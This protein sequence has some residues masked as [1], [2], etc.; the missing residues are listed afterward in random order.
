M[1]LFERFRPA[2]QYRQRADDL[3]IAGDKRRC[4]VGEAG[5]GAGD[6]NALGRKA[7]ILAGIRNQQRHATLQHPLASCRC[8]WLVGRLESEARLEPEPVVVHPAHV[9]I[10]GVAQYRRKLRQLIQRGVGVAIEQAQFRAH[11][12][13]LV[14]SA[15]RTEHCA[16]KYT[17]PIVSIGEIDELD[18]STNRS[19]EDKQLTTQ[20]PPVLGHRIS[21]DITLGAF[22]SYLLPGEYRHT[23]SQRVAGRRRNCSISLFGPRLTRRMRSQMPGNYEIVDQCFR[24]SFNW[25]RNDFPRKL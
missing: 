19:I 24:A 20:V 9:G 21:L 8:A 10:I 22:P 11:H 13:V 7:R 2:R 1:F 15:L 17:H 4:R 6:R 18:S 16:H 14:L 12:R 5:T 23:T 25:L 3:L